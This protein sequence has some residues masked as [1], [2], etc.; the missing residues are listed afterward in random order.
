MTGLSD[1]Y[2][3]HAPG[4]ASWRQSLRLRP[5]AAHRRDPRG[6]SVSDTVTSHRRGVSRPCRSGRGLGDQG[7]L[8]HHHIRQPRCR[9]RLRN[10][11]GRL[12][13]ERVRVRG[14]GPWCS[15]AGAASVDRRCPVHVVGHGPLVFVS[16][17]GHVAHGVCRRGPL[18]PGS[19][20]ATPCHRQRME[21]S[22]DAA[23]G[24]SAWRCVS[25]CPNRTSLPAKRRETGITA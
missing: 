3:Q 12:G 23:D 18:W 19:R 22:L 25:R 16:H 7:V 1:R 5:S 11:A 20:V 15:K 9:R 10:A 14:G 8:P 21:A 4:G 17:R 2:R 24:R 6:S 13:A